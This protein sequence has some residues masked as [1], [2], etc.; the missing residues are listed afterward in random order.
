MVA[1]AVEN[2]FTCR[3]LW[4][5]SIILIYSIVEEL[6]KKKNIKKGKKFFFFYLFSS[7]VQVK[8]LGRSRVVVVGVD[9]GVEKKMREKKRGNKGHQGTDIE[10]TANEGIDRSCWRMLSGN[11]RTKIPGRETSHSRTLPT[12]FF[13]LNVYIFFSV[14]CKGLKWIF[15][16][17]INLEKKFVTI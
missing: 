15:S 2:T 12:M 3:V 11:K 1:L 13:F 17:A 4:K 9:D 6:S 10:K 16:F 8:S 7:K 14:S 5:N